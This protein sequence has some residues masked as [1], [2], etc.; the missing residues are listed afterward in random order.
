M[1]QPSHI[2]VDVVNGIVISELR[3]TICKTTSDLPQAVLLHLWSPYRGRPY[4]EG[5]AIGWP[6]GII[7]GPGI[8]LSG[9]IKLACIICTCMYYIYILIL[10]DFKAFIT[11]S[12]AIG[13]HTA[14]VSDFARNRFFQEYCI[15]AFNNNYYTEL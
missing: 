6:L 9:A 3:I 7:P 14:H 8:P 15:K 11:F 10:V 12:K 13:L 2:I 4:R 1:L 5:S